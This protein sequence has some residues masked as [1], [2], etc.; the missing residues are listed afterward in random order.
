M[1]ATIVDFKHDLEVVGEGCDDGNQNPWD[2][3]DQFCQARLG[4]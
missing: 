3:C 2:G 4:C 1:Q